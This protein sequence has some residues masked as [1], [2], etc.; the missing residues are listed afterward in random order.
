MHVPAAF[1]GDH[2]DGLPHEPPAELG[3]L[4]AVVGIDDHLEGPRVVAAGDLRVGDRSIAVAVAGDQR[5]EPGVATRGEVEPQVV[6]Q[7]LLAL[8]GRG[9]PQQRADLG[10]VFGRHMALHVDL[11][12]GPEGYV[13]NSTTP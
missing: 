7:R 10:D 3:Q 6:R 8:G 9:R 1:A 11:Q 13:P 4:V 12:H 2:V 5:R